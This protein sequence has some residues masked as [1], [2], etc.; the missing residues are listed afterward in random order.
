MHS[1]YADTNNERTSLLVPQLEEWKAE[2]A[3]SISKELTSAADYGNALTK[4]RSAIDDLLRKSEGTEREKKI[5]A[6]VDGLVENEQYKVYQDTKQLVDHVASKTLLIGV[7]FPEAL[8]VRAFGTVNK[9]VKN[10]TFSVPTISLKEVVKT[11]EDAN[12]AKVK[13]QWEFVS[14]EEYK[15]SAYAVNVVK[16]AVDEDDE[17]KNDDDGDWK[18]LEKPDIKQQGQNTYAVDVADC[19]AGGKAYRFQIDHVTPS[20]LMVVCSNV[21]KMDLRLK[22][23]MSREAAIPLAVH[24]HKGHYQTY[25]P[26]IFLNSDNNYYLSPDGQIT[27]DW[28]VLEVTDGAF[29][30]PTKI[31]VRHR[32]TGQGFGGDAYGLKRFRMKI[33]SASSNEWVELNANVFHT[34]QT[35]PELQTFNLDI[36]NNGASAAVMQ[37][38]RSIKAKGFKQ[39]RLEVL[40]NYGEC[41]ILIQ[42]LKILGVKV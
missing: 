12:G 33:G 1:T 17:A 20:Y 23:D 40:D 6:I 16:W 3:E 31:Q 8:D 29:Y 9:A 24:S 14:D 2:K 4:S 36:V 39:F 34:S 10:A 37:K 18:V 11:Q 15:A 42:E 32:G 22:L 5:K 35:K 19:F 21:A 38:W 28:I 26:E 41:Y 27:N 13:L 7:T 30:Y 25:G